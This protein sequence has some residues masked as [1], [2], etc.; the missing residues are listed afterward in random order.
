VSSE[1]F[2]AVAGVADVVPGRP[3]TVVIDGTEV[4]VFNV[5]GTF[6]ALEDSCPHQGA[7]LS[8]GWIEG[9]TVTCPWH[10]WCF[11]LTDGKMTV[12][13]DGVDTFDVKVE[14]GTIWVSRTPRR[15]AEA[16]P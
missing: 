7:P 5:G 15:D 9:T 16:R 4:A 3:R 6:Y 1:P 12:G 11:N 10:A 8:D 13:F 2:V 14:N